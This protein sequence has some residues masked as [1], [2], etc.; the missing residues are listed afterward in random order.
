MSNDFWIASLVAV[1]FTGVVVFFK[2]EPELE[3]HGE[4]QSIILKLNAL[5]RDVEV[6]K[7]AI[8]D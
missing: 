5:T 6:I 3:V 8:E 1:V 2:K 7:K 4:L